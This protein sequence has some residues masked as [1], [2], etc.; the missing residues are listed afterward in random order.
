[1]GIA[2]IVVGSDGVESSK[3]KETFGALRE[4]HED[5]KMVGPRLA[6]STDPRRSRAPGPGGIESRSFS[7]SENLTGHCMGM[8]TRTFRLA[9]RPTRCRRHSQLP[10][11]VSQNRRNSRSA[12]AAN[13]TGAQ[14]L[15]VLGL[16]CPVGSHSTP[17]ALGALPTTT[18]PPTTESTP[19]G[20]TQRTPPDT[21]GTQQTRRSKVC[22]PHFCVCTFRRLSPT[23]TPTRGQI[24]RSAHVQRT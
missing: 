8:T 11:Q 5:A 23:P 18:V 19:R 7:R 22:G 17:P 9:R 10:L 24:A 14:R 21:A 12:L 20:P 16:P 2:G 3:R 1:M 6:D 4:K 15:P 13:P